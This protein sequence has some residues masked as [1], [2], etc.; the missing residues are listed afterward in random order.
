M[1]HRKRRSGLVDFMD[2]AAHD[3]GAVMSPE[4]A[5]EIEELAE[6]HEKRRLED[7][8]PA[9]DRQAG[10]ILPTGEEE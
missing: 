1:K 8:N 6:A 2:N 7:E 3:E 9:H 10:V 5:K 4:E